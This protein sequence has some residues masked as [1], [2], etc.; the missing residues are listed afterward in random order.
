M[1][2]NIIILYKDDFRML[3]QSIFQVIL[4]LSKVLPEIQPGVI[5][6]TNIHTKIILL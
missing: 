4:T 5:S 6:K 3:D 1:L 2:L